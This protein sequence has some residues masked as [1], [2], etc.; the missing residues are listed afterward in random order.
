MRKLRMAPADVVALKDASPDQWEEYLERINVK[1]GEVTLIGYNDGDV[2][3]IVACT[4]EWVDAVDKL[5]KQLDQLPSG[6]SYEIY[7]KFSNGNVRRYS[8]DY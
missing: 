8:K 6:D 1:Q 4:E 2:E 7:W 5:R 3:I